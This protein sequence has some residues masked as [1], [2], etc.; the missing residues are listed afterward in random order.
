MTWTEEQRKEYTALVDKKMLYDNLTLDEEIQ[1]KEYRHLI[2]IEI[3]NRQERLRK[4][5][6]AKIQSAL[7]LTSD[8][9][10]AFC[11]WIRR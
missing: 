5:A 8:E 7:G 11:D 2:E 4:S 6:F 1:L 3:R 9:L 10:K